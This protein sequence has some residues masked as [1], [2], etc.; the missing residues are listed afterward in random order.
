M[1]EIHIIMESHAICTYLIGKYGGE[2]NALYPRDLHAR[3]RIDQRMY[4]NNGQVYPAAAN[5]VKAILNDG[6]TGPSP[7]QLQ[8]AI[9]TYAVLEK[10]LATDLYMAG[11]Q[12]T[13]ADLALSTSVSQLNGTVP[14]V[15]Y[16]YPKISAWLARLGELPYYHEANTLLLAD[17]MKKLEGK[18]QKNRE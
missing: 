14:L 15:E 6:A 5:I 17:F 13:L 11:A 16:T 1:D 8:Y 3:S 10:F 12:P 9:Q 2:D 18:L 7:D 4:F